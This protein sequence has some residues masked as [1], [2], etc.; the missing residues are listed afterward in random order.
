MSSV[1]ENCWSEIWQNVVRRGS[2]VVKAW[3]RVVWR[4]SVMA[5]KSI[6][7]PYSAFTQTDPRVLHD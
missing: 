4:H 7:F 6:L 3:E 1:L 5:A 2:N